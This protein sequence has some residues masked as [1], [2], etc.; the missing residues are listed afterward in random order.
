MSDDIS[1]GLSSLVVCFDFRST[2]LVHLNLYFHPFRC[3]RPLITQLRIVL[4]DLKIDKCVS[5]L[6]TCIEHF[7]ICTRS[8][9]NLNFCFSAIRT[10]TPV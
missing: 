10:E 3:H 2:N 7:A 4:I 5:D 9:E 8:C 1:L 6:E